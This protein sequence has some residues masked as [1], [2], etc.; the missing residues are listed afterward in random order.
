M[1]DGTRGAH[2]IKVLA[3]RREGRLVEFD[4]NLDAMPQALPHDGGGAFAELRSEGQLI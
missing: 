3:I 1:V 4:R 2:L